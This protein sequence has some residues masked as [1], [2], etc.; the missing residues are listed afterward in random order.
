MGVHRAKSGLKLERCVVEHTKGNVLKPL[1]VSGAP[2]HLFSLALCE[3]V[4]RTF[5]CRASL[6]EALST[7]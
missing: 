5:A 1:Q 4:S 6:H 2:D 3:F 7:L